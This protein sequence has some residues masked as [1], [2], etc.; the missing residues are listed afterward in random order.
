[1]E[2]DAQ[3]AKLND[4]LGAFSGFPGIEEAPEV[5][6]FKRGVANI[7]I[8][9]D[10]LENPDG[11][12]HIDGICLLHE[13]FCTRAQN[14]ILGSKF[15]FIYAYEDAIS[16]SERRVKPVEVST[17]DLSSTGIV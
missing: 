5:K 15:V 13:V 1:M 12:Y 16:K 4:V 10:P 3:V 6:T 7:T 2:L 14:N 17:T 8:S 9:W 11:E